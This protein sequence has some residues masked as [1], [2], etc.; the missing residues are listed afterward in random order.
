MKKMH[1]LWKTGDTVIYSARKASGHRKTRL[2][3]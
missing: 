3:I 1:D 2:G